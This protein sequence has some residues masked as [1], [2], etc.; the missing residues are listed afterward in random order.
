MKAR[1]LLTLVL[2]L[3]AWALPTLAQD[4]AIDDLGALRLDYAT[5]APGDGYSGP[6]LAAEV[7]FRPGEALSLVTP[8]RIQ[9]IAY[10]VE[11]GAQVAAGQVLAELSG[12]EI[13]H[14]LTE[15]DVIGQRYENA[16]KRFERNRKLY[17]Q[18]AI[19]EGRWQ[20]ISDSYFTLRL[21]YEHLRHFT[22]LLRTADD[23]PERISLL[24]PAAG[25]VQYAQA[26]PGI[27]EGGELA[28]IVPA[29]ALRLRVAVPIEARQGLAQ[30]RF[31]DCALA[32]D[33][34]SG[35]ADGF[36][37]RA[38][39]APLAEDCALLPGQQLM[40]RPFY[41]V[42]GYEIPREALLHW[43]GQPALLLRAG[44]RLQLAPVEILGAT[45]TGYYVDSEASLAGADILASSVS[46]VQGILLGLGGE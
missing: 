19:D 3:T 14:M 42:A 36:F 18:Q 44:P 24:A 33:S 4:V 15:A 11:P 8:A 31:G 26:Q 13:H 43:N 10:R 41:A 29:Q 2:T 38:W 17:Q 21:E 35:I 37:L 32:V 12:P 5:V 34:I 20:E 30:L 25:R 28:L 6:P 27:P 40:V 23:D 22:E 39:S 16:R 1:Y 46:A 45:A 9:Q 7:T